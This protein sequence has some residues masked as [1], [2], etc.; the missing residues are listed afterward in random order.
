[1]TEASPA[2]T[3]GGGDDTPASFED[4]VKV[5]MDKAK[6]MKIGELKLKLQAK[7]VLTSGFCEKQEF[8]RAYAE[9]VV[10]DAENPSVLSN[11]ETPESEE[12]DEDGGDDADGSV[13]DELP[14]YV[15]KRVEKLKALHEE[16][17]RGMKEYLAE[18]AQLEAKYQA[19]AQPLYQKRADIISGKLDQE[20]ANQSEGNPDDDDDDEKVKGLPQFW[21]LA[22]ARMG[23]VADL[24]SEEDISC[25]ESLEDVKCADDENGQGFTLS[26]HFSENEYFEN[27]MLTKRYEV[28]NLL[29]SDEPILK[30]VKGCE[31]QWKKGKCLTYSEVTQKQRG[32]GKHSGQVRTVVKKEKR[33]SF[34]HFFSPPKMPDMADMNE[35]EAVRLEAEFDADYDVAQ[36]FRSQIIP[37]A[38]LWYTGHAMEQEMEDAMDGLKWPDGHAASSDE[39][40]ECKQS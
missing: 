18:R 20:I 34:F 25:L 8:V 14:A 13:A 6:D 12:D 37:K 17:E 30:S 16:R 36:A 21:V 10:R 40:P 1:M 27:S 26:F 5:E 29:L 24:L 15:Q 9:S 19:L 28:P 39:T 3:E 31:I 4:K 11:L 32:K 38:I 23:V 33:D 7:G 22:L 2:T 35:E